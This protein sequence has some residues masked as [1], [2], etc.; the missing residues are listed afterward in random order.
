M[1]RQGLL[2]FIFSFIIG[3]AF[4][5]P[6][7]FLKTYSTGN[8]GYAVREL[9]GNSYV[10][11]GGTDYYYNFH[12]S[13]MSA[14]AGTN[15]HLFKTTD[16]GTLIW[17]K[18]FSKPL[19]RT[20]ATWVE[21]TN[22][23]GFILTGRSNQ[24]LVWPPDSN[25]VL[26]I[27]CNTDGDIQWAKKFDS[28]KDE[29]G[30]CVRQT[31]DA[32]YAIS[33]FH[34]SSPMSL[35]GTTY[36]MLIK[37]DSSGNLLWDKSYEFAVR[38]LDTGEGLTW[39]FS[40]TADSGY[41]LTGTTVGAHQADLYVIRT[42]SNGD[43]LWAKSYEHDPSVNRF[44]LGLD[45]IESITGEIVIAGSMDKDHSSNEYNY[46]YI[47]KLTASGD[48]SKADIYASVPAQAFQSGFSSVEQ[49]PDGG[50]LFTGMG[51]YGGFGDQAQILKTDSGLNMQWSRSYT[52][53]GI[54]TMG[55]RS[56]RSTSDG[57]Y[58][59]T[60]KKQLAGTVLLK[61]D[62]SGLVP[63]KNP[64]S[65]FEITPSLN[66]QNRF[67]L[68]ISGL[69]STDIVFNTT[70]SAVDTT[71]LCPVTPSHLPV[72]LTTLS[73]TFITD[74]Q[75]QVAW[76]TA[77]ETNNDYFLVER[78]IDG[79]QFLKTGFVKGHGNSTMY[80]EYSFVDNEI[81]KV[82]IIYYRL[83][84]V[85]YDGKENISKAVTPGKN[86]EAF[87][88]INTQVNQIDGTLTFYIH[89]RN[90]QKTELRLYDLLGRNVIHTSEELNE[91]FNN[92][93]FDISILSS[94]IYFFSL[95]NG[96]ES[97]SGKLFY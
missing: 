40:Q 26:L 34:D 4:A 76:E 70:I 48:I 87:S 91:G 53:D 79:K 77:S 59:F 58:I 45:I 33:A 64:A 27:K 20:I 71:T 85:D 49:C 74:H 10:V 23:G 78:S 84:Q 14:I 16:D 80:H 37:T 18:V 81:P 54:A 96:S 93:T 50:Y 24:D 39:V 9:N 75:V 63:C 5:Q 21:V 61:T 82:E 86:T 56:G 2:F 66:V 11:A 12:W 19:T 25:D 92:V 90:N 60:G 72:E 30:F 65:L 8:S 32:G 31:F 94:G 51:G 6:N 46:P 55:S 29:L 35:S 52:M 38:D 95:T 7:T 41:V 44:S 97:L 47:L 28:G 68:T 3:N 67:P 13:I 42:N 17:E 1:R 83:R 69:I 43:V 15:I 89:S 36:A 88:L 57:S 73:A 62:F 22:D